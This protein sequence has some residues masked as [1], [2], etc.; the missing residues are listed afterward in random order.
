MDNS[1]FL[2]KNKITNRIFEID[3]FRGIAVLFMIFDHLVYNF[4][5]LLPIFF[6]DYP[7]NGTLTMKLFQWSWLYWGWDKR[8]I[9]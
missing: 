7:K 2:Y 5:D 1:K 6:S 4:W 8:I 9:V 3:L